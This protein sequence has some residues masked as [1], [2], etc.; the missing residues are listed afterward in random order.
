M[1]RASI[2]SVPTR[3]Q[4]SGFS[5]ADD[6]ACFAVKTPQVRAI[7][8]D[9]LIEALATNGRDQPF[10]KRRSARDLRELDTISTI[11]MLA[12]VRFNA[13]L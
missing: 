12:T 11:S 5:N 4:V 10:D 3:H 1:V 8:D 6:P 2:A 13:A 9:Q 7:Q